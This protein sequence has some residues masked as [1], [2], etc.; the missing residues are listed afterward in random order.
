[1]NSLSRRTNSVRNCELYIWKKQKGPKT[2]N[3]SIKR[4]V[5]S[6][7]MVFRA[8][9]HNVEMRVLNGLLIVPFHGIFFL[10]IDTDLYTSKKWLVEAHDLRLAKMLFL[11]TPIFNSRVLKQVGVKTLA[12]QFLSICFLYQCDSFSSPGNCTDDYKK[13]IFSVIKM[14]AL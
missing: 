3:A 12:F 1:M 6:L 10:F 8:W 9:A 7:R 2:T 5:F 4:S 11:S 14:N 13:L